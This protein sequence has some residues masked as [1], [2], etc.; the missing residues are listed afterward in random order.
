MWQSKFDID[1]ASS[2]KSGEGYTIFVLSLRRFNHTYF[3]AMVDSIDGPKIL[4]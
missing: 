4:L 3:Y 2:D 1:T